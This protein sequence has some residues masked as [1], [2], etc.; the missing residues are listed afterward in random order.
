MPPAS[1]L[2][3][4]V[5]WTLLSLCLLAGHV[6][7][8]GP[9]AYGIRLTNE[10]AVW[11]REHPRVR[12]VADP[13]WAPFTSLNAEHRYEGADVEVLRLAGQ[14]LGITF[15]DIPCDSWGDA[16]R[17]L[18]AGGAEV[19]GSVG[20]SPERREHLLFSEPYFEFPVAIIAR[21]DAP[22]F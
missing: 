14:R 8:Q 2:F 21:H 9:E 16:L 6:R 17:V 7:A 19:A 13:A 10:E 1:P 3:L 4:R 12:L 20:E 5:W 11:L 15:E 22:F 18:Y